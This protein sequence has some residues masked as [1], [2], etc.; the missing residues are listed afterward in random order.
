[1]ET[2]YDMIIPDWW[3]EETGLSYRWSGSCS[4][5]EWEVSF[6]KLPPAGKSTKDELVPE[7]DDTVRKSEFL[8]EW[9]E[10]ILLEKDEPINIGAVIQAPGVPRMTPEGA[11][12]PTTSLCV[13]ISAMSEVELKAQLPEHYR[14][15]L[16]LFAPQMAKELPKHRSYDH[17]IDLM[18][19]TTPPWGPVYS[20]S[21]V[22]LKALREFLDD[23]V[24]TGKIRPSKS[25][26]GAP[27]L[28]V[29]KP[30]GRG[31]RLCVD[32]HGLNKIT[33]KNRYPLPLMD[34]LRDRVH[35][36]TIF[37]KIDLKHG[38]NLVR[39]KEGDEWQT[40]FRT[41][42]GHY[43]F[44][45][46]PFGLTNAPATFQ[47]MMNNVLREFLDLGVIVYMDDI[48]IYS[49]DEAEHRVLVKKVLQRLMD[50]NLAAEIDKCFFD[51]REDEFLGYIMSPDGISIA[52]KTV[53]T[54]EEWEAP[55]SV[56]D[57]QSLHGFC[58][59]LSTLY[60]Q[61]FWSLLTYY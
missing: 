33:V 7:N 54:I 16:K 44:L 49:R 39:I 15:F 11:W 21:E 24:Q 19:G 20:M 5:T 14:Q 9:D 58:Q 6:S 38:Y 26:A 61:L 53:R 37:T 2:G 8:V 3:R 29:P 10:S 60:T 59:L 55:I 40:A 52:D 22:E 31:L 23:M 41:R 4:S 47:A 48:L 30:N 32:Y 13:S 34:E 50:N 17:A 25:P 12:I 51:V 28:F 36:S 18:P 46:M 43:E 45:V 35:E 27:I 1:M 42:Y 56:K 57:I